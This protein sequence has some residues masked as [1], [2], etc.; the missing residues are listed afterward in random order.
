MCFD[1]R[2]TVKRVSVFRSSFFLTRRFRENQRCFFAS[3]DLPVLTLLLIK[4][5]LGPCAAGLANLAP[6]VFAQVPDS[7]ALLG[8]RRSDRADVGGE[9]AD[10]P[11]VD[12][13]DFHIRRTVYR[14]IETLGHIDFDGMGKAE[15]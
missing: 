5:P 3:I 11:F 15:R 14:N 13:F 9:L 12:P 1:V 2:Y 4:F 6:H 8:F 7:L 10:Q